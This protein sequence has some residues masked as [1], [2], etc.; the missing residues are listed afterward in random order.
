VWSWRNEAASRGGAFAVRVE[1]GG[2]G[3]LLSFEIGGAPFG[4]AGGVFE[5]PFRLVGERLEVGAA[6][7]LLGRVSARIGLD[8]TAEAL[9]TGPPALGPRG[10][11]RLRNYRLADGLLRFELQ[12]ERGDGSAAQTAVVEAA[13]ARR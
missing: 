11:A 10:S 7:E 5:A 4:G 1:A 2:G 3:G 13:C 12:V 8:G 9:L 6:S